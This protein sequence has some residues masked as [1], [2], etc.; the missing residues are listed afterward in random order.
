MGDF[1]DGLH[2]GEFRR[3]RMSRRQ[4][5]K[6]CELDTGGDDDD[7]DQADVVVVVVAD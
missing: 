5:R 3:A 7:D 2:V 6:N 1:G 4:N